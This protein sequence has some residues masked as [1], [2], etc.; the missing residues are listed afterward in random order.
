M[1]IRNVHRKYI[2]QYKV[3]F[4][5]NTT[6]VVSLVIRPYILPI[7]VRVL[8]FQTIKAKLLAHL[9][10]FPSINQNFGNSS[11]VRQTF[12]STPVAMEIYVFIILDYCSFFHNTDFM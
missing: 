8:V 11:H 3:V 12:P 6:S 7:D 1:T 5:R 10:R 2:N 4:L 9:Q